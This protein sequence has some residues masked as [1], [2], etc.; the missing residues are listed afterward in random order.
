MLLISRTQYNKTH[1]KACCSH[2]SCHPHLSNHNLTKVRL[3]TRFMRYLMSKN[4][5]SNRFQRGGNLKALKHFLKMF[6]IL[7]WSWAVPMLS[8]I[9]VIF[10]EVMHNQAKMSASLCQA[11]SKRGALYSSQSEWSPASHLSL[12][13]FL[14]VFQWPEN[15]TN[16]SAVP[17]NLYFKRFVQM[18]CAE[19]V[20]SNNTMLIS[21]GVFSH[22]SECPLWEN[23]TEKLH[24]N[25]NHSIKF[26]LDK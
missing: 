11:P 3:Q 15:W 4:K 17:G 21:T 25:Q 14:M 13:S 6:S 8:G 9:W 7:P 16:P 19:Q 12:C 24:W 10:T 20:A 22:L 2:T 18:A 23:V 26:V 1:A 5:R